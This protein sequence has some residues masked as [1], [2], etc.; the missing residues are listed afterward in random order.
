VADPSKLDFSDWFSVVATSLV[1]GM[2]AAL[3]F[4]RTSNNKRDTRIRQVEDAM[5]QWDERHATHT[6]DIAVIETCQEN[7]A[8]QLEAIGVTT[9]DTNENLKELS[10]TVTQVLLAIQAKK[11]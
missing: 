5:R 2:G 4:F 3:G 6:T 11:L 10:Q 8:K 1:A 7:T 9:R